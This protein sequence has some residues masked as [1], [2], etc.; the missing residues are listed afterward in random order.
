MPRSIPAR[1]GRLRTSMLPSVALRPR[2]G[3][4]LR[5]PSADPRTFVPSPSYDSQEL[6]TGMGPSRSSTRGPVLR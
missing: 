1:P 5:T 4:V 3:N 2:V 6:G